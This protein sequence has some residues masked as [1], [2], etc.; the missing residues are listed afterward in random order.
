MRWR[1]A[2]VVAQVACHVLAMK[3]IAPHKVRPEE[4][5]GGGGDKQHNI[6]LRQQRTKNNN[7]YSDNETNT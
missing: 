7:F 4:G 1:F 3:V 5:G 6:M 2:F